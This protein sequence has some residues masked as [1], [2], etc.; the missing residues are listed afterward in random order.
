MILNYFSFHLLPREIDVGIPNSQLTNQFDKKYKEF[1]LSIAGLLSSGSP[2]L[3]VGRSS[4]TINFRSGN[5]RRRESNS[6]GGE[7]NPSSPRESS[8]ETKP[9]QEG[10]IPPTVFNTGDF[11]NRGR[12]STSEEEEVDV[13]PGFMRVDRP[14]RTVTQSDNRQRNKGLTDLLDLGKSI[15]DVERMRAKKRNDTQMTSDGKSRANDIRF[16]GVLPEP[17]KLMHDE[18]D[19]SKEKESKEMDDKNQFKRIESEEEDEDED[20]EAS[21]NLP[22][23]GNRQE[24]KRLAEELF[25]QQIDSE[26]EVSLRNQ[27]ESPEKM[28]NLVD[29]TFH[30]ELNPKKIERQNSFL[31]KLSF[32]H[33]KI[34]VTIL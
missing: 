11:R 26:S 4:P 6:S 16:C 18:Y 8:S 28:T 19:E 9:D 10:E 25:S 31:K 22:K 5:T 30:D 21:W 17:G 7:D 13:V 1:C 2:I 29:D 3:D 12:L 14:A 32:H 24:Q 34:L 15:R 20:E 33:T 27:Y 23:L